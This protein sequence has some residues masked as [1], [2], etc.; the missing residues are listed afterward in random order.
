MSFMDFATIIRAARASSGLSQRELGIRVGV[1]ENTIWELESRGSGTVAL[2]AKIG[3]ALDLRFAGL[4]KGQSFSDQIRIL[5]QRRGWTQVQLASTAGVSVSTIVNLERGNA[6]IATLAAALVV[7][8]PKARVRK[9]DVA[10]WGTGARDERFTSP[11][12]LERII[13]VI[14]P[15]TIDP[16]GHRESPVQAERIY[17]QE[18]DGLK[19]CWSGRTTFVNPP[20]TAT[21]KFVEKARRSWSEGDCETV[22]LLL[23]TQCHHRWFHNEVVGYADVF[24]L[25]GRI[26]FYRPG[27]KP[28]P[29]PLGNMFVAY[30]FDETR[31]ERMLSTFDCVHLPRTARVGKVR[32]L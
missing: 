22:L 29:A 5:R 2:L 20:Y 14:G 12:L 7:L 4:P 18:D 28:G 26:S 13:S 15:I 30:G 19:Q 10:A 1:T 25:N 24:F 11:E 16:C 32:G 23:Q 8:A 17:Y 9:S 6:R 27:H 21:A 31:I 3:A